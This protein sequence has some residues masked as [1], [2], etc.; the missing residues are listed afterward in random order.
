MGNP[1]SVKSV[2]KP[3]EL[4]A[5]RK[6]LLVIRLKGRFGQDTTDRQTFSC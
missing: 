6:V 2:L 5:I 4:K 3:G 1:S